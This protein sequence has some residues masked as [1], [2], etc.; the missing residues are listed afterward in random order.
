VEVKSSRAAPPIAVHISNAIQLQA[1]SGKPLLLVVVLVDVVPEG[2]ETLSDSVRCLREMLESDPVAK[3]AADERLFEAGWLDL[4][5]E[6]GA[7]HFA[8]R[9]TRVYEVRAGFPRITEAELP[10]G[11]GNLR[12]SVDLSACESFRIADGDLSQRIF[13]DGN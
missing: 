4:P 9:G 6:P 5:D 11:V 1:I 10:V 12:Y 8:Q 7:L 3:Q 2:G 13:A